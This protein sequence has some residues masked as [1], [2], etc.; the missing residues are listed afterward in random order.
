MTLK[1]ALEIYD[2]GTPLVNE[3][4]GELV[5]VRGPSVKTLIPANAKKPDVAV[6]MLLNDKQVDESW[7]EISTDEAWKRCKGVLLNGAERV[8]HLLRKKR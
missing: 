1:T 4:T 2:E 7:K 6:N 5:V 8:R 3:L